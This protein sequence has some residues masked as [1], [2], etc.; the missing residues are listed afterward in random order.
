MFVQNTVQVLI[1]S[2]YLDKTIAFENAFVFMN[3]NMNKILQDK[4]GH[5]PY[6]SNG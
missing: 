3:T 5:V 2:F 4:G 1:S 6:G